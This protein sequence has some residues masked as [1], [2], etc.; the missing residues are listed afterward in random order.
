MSDED[1]ALSRTR[2]PDD[3]GRRSRFEHEVELGE[4][5]GSVLGTVVAEAHIP[6]FDSRRAISGGLRPAPSAACV[7]RGASMMLRRRVST[8]REFSTAPERS[9]STVKGSRNR[10]VTISSATAS[11][12]PIW[13]RTARVVIVPASTMRASWLATLNNSCPGIWNSSSLMVAPCAVATASPVWLRAAVARRLARSACCVRANSRMRSVSALC[14]RP[15]AASAAR[16]IRWLANSAASNNGSV[17]AAATPSCQ[18]TKNRPT[19]IAAGSSTAPRNGVSRF[20]TKDDQIRCAG[21]DGLPRHRGVVGGEPAE[22]DVGEPVGHPVLGVVGQ[23]EADAVTDARLDHI[24]DPS[25]DGGRGESAEPRQ[26]I[27]R[28]GAEQGAE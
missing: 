2:R 21:R 3:R 1:R 25:A 26:C 8:P 13:P 10:T 7:P 18:E 16:T 11:G 24:D 28:C 14:A 5:V 19:V 6:E 17:I 27:R 22:R 12:A 20:A 23:C 15:S 4:H 9:A